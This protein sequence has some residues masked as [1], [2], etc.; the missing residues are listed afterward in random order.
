[1]KKTLLAMVFATSMVSGCS[2][3]GGQEAVSYED[4]RNEGTELYA[5]SNTEGYQPSTVQE[6]EVA[7][8]SVNTAFL[9]AKPVYERYT[10]ELLSTPELGNYF[11]ATEAAETEEEK[12]AIYEALTPEQKETVDNFMES[13][14][15]DEMMSGLGEAATVALSNASHFLALDTTSMI[16]GVEFSQLMAETDLIETTIEQVD[17]LDSTIVSAYQNYKIISAFNS[18][19]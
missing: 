17:Y 19:E 3:I 11:A 18:A 10:D 16:S 1:M 14:I 8:F 2:M 13:S 12:L 5:V 6:L 15:A 7:R 9:A 4:L